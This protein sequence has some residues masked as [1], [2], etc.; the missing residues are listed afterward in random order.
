MAL[1]PGVERR[2]V[3]TA[4]ASAAAD[5]TMV[6][7]EAWHAAKATLGTDA[8]V[9]DRLERVADLAGRRG[10]FSSRASVLVEVVGLTP[11]GSRKQARLVAAAEATLATG[12]AELAR[13]MLDGFHTARTRP[14]PPPRRR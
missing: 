10:G 11:D 1:P 2:R 7:L 9:A 6:E 13:T 3:H 14:A 4:L 5:L 8:G 12:A